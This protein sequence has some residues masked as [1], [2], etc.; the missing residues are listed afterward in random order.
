MIGVDEVGRGALA[1]P[2]VVAAVAVPNYGGETSIVKVRDSKQLKP[3]AREEVTEALR[4]HPDVRIALA[5]ITP[6]M[7]DHLGMT[8]AGR[9]AVWRA[10]E[11]LGNLR[12]FVFLDGGLA[13]PERFS[14]LTIIRGDVQ[15]PVIA[16]A[17]IV[18]K[19]HRDSFMQR[20]HNRFPKYGFDKHVGYGT[21]A[22]YAALR[23]HGPSPIHR[24]SFRLA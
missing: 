5:R 22:H 6:G 9:I 23:R 7:V 17:S 20:Q 24:R 10:L 3:R 14:Q 16:A 11:A 1:G 4:A 15:L 2:L 8:A 12:A 19:V 21:R 18:A 13:A